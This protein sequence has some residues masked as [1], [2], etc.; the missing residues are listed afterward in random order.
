MVVDRYAELYAEMTAPE[1]PAL[2]VPGDRTP[3]AA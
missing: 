2:L 1:A 3:L